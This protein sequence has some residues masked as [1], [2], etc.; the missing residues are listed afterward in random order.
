MNSTPLDSSLT[1]YVAG[2]RG[3]VGSALTRA[4]KR[5]GCEN[6]ITATSAELDLR[7][8]VAT[9][10]FISTRRPDVHPHRR[11]EGRWDPREQHLPGRLHL[12]QSHD[13]GQPGAGRA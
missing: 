8:Q 13:R 1:Y 12:R 6:L 9:R 3:M 5:A 7:D 2:H 4:L 10:E 11:S